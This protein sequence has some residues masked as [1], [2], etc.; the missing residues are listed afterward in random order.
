MTLAPS[1]DLIGEAKF[2]HLSSN[3]S[4][5]TQKREQ[6]PWLDSS[7]AHEAAVLISPVEE[8]HIDYIL[9]EEFCTNPELLSFFVE[10]AR[11]SPS[12]A[13]RI[14]SQAEE[15]KCAA[16]RSVTTDNG[17]SDVLV[18]YQSENPLPVAILIEDKIRAGF[19]PTQPNRYRE[20]GE[21]GKGEG[22][23]DY[24]TC[25]IAHR[26]YVSS[27]GDFDAIV[28]LQDLQAY[29]VARPDLRSQFRARTLAHAIQKYEVTGLQKKDETVTRF[30]SLY[31]EA[32]QATFPSDRL[33][34]QPARDAWWG[35]TRFDCRGT[36]WPKGVLLRHQAEA[37]RIQLIFPMYDADL[38]HSALQS[39]AA[40]QAS[41]VPPSIEV[42]PV[43][44]GKSA[45]Q[46]R[47]P[48]IEDFS[49]VASFEEFFTAIEY[50]SH[51]YDRIS[52]MLPSTL[53]IETLAPSAT[54]DDAQIRA[55]RVMLLAFM[56]STVIT[57]GTAMPFPLP[58]LEKLGAEG[59]IDERY[60]ASLGLM[61]GFELVLHHEQ[62]GTPYIIATQSSRQWGTYE[63]RHRITTDEVRLLETE[64]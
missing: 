52:D 17:E 57:L 26:K 4:R 13:P 49:S 23:S 46:L 48:R 59:S 51:F 58:R 37:G 32:F 39:H 53:Q 36:N 47:V 14:R 15:H 1:R 11:R 31:S 28:T 12:D 18:T 45:F 38:F 22:W 40:W 29:F 16:A 55:L 19:Q 20:R 30:R 27:P 7:H 64:A 6:L 35:D 62:N 41:S 43:G 50:L 2:S 44:K 10:T 54:T 5:L 61:G 63:I 34:H 42:V 8:R 25:L 60:F 9:E 24:W 56:R 3:L 33:W 21:A